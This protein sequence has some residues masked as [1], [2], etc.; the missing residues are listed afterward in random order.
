MQTVQYNILV[1]FAHEARELS[2][3]NGCNL[4]QKS[5]TLLA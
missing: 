2:Q 5:W 3:N 4:Y 1:I